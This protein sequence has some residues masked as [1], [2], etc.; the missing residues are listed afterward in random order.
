MKGCIKFNCSIY[1]NSNN[2]RRLI[3]IN[4]INNLSK[5]KTKS[6]T[7]CVKNSVSLSLKKLKKKYK[8]K[9]NKLYSKIKKISLNSK[10]LKEK[11]KNQ[12]SQKRKKKVKR[13]KVKRKKV[14]KPN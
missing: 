1:N 4:K 12:K 9:R 7:R 8:N 2:N 14:N 5:K 6:N 3:P 13:K 11:S 10:C